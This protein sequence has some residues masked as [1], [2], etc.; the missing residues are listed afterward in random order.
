MPGFGDVVENAVLDCVF[1]GIPYPF[2]S[3]TFLAL[4]SADPTDAGLFELAG[5]SYARQAVTWVA[6]SGGV[7]TLAGSYDFNGLPA[8]TIAF[9]GVW[10]GGG[11]YVGSGTLPNVTL[12]NGDSYRVQSGTSFT[13]T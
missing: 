6:A 3:G 5:L 7:V 1:R 4:H 13:L 10:T 9:Y 2:T 11:Q 8:G 12:N